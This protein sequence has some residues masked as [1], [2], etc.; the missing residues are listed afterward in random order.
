MI[1]IKKYA[2]DLSM[3]IGPIPEVA[4]PQGNWNIRIYL[5]S[6]MWSPGL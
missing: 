1:G 3:I 6:L 4:F 2:T 5:L